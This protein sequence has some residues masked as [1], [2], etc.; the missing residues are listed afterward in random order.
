[1]YRQDASA[2][3]SGQRRAVVQRRRAES[4][5]LTLP[6]YPEGA[7]GTPNAASVTLGR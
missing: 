3:P 7:A 1:M 2:T 4:E 6:F 5:V